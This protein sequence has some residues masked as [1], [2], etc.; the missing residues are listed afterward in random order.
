LKY[1][2]I[3][4]SEDGVLIFKRYTLVLMG[5]W[6]AVANVLPISLLVKPAVQ[7]VG[8]YEENFSTY[9]YSDY[10][11]RA[12]WDIWNGRMALASTDAV[13]HKLPAM[14][15]N[16]AGTTV[17]VW[18]RGEHGARDIYAQ[19]LDA[20]GNPLWP[21]DVRVPL[22]LS[23]SERWGPSVAVDESGNAFIVWSDM[24]NGHTDVYAQKL[25]PWG[26][27]TWDTDVR[28]NTDLGTANQWG[29]EVAVDSLANIWIAWSDYRNGDGDIYAQRINPN[30]DQLLPEDVR[31]N[32]DTGEASQYGSDIA[33]VDGE[34]LVVVWRDAT[35]GLNTLYAQRVDGEGDHL[36]TTDQLVSDS[37]VSYQYPVFSDVAADPEGYVVVVWSY[38][39]SYG[40]GTPVYAQRLT[41]EG[42]RLWA[43]DVEV[44]ASPSIE[45]QNAPA[46]A[47]SDTGSAYVAW[48]SR[49]SS[50]SGSQVFAQRLDVLGHRVWITDTE[51]SSAHDIVAYQSFTTLGI[52]SVGEVT[53]VW[54]DTRHVSSSIF[55]QRLTTSGRPLWGADVRVNTGSGTAVQETPAVAMDRHGN[56]FVVWQDQ[57]NGGYDIYAQKFDQVGHRL[58][59]ADVQVASDVS[60]G[61][62]WPHPSMA[63]DGS[64]N[65]IVVWMGSQGGNRD[66]YAQKL[67]G[68]GNLQWGKGVRV[69]A[70]DATIDQDDW[71]HPS[72]SAYGDTGVVVVWCDERDG[73]NRNIYVQKIDEHG[74]RAWSD[75]KRV[76]AMSVGN[77]YSPMVASNA[78]HIVVAWYWNDG[79]ENRVL[80]Q[81]LDANGDRVWGD[82]VQ[83][84]TEA[85]SVWAN[86]SLAVGIDPHGLASVAWED[87]RNDRDLYMQRVDITG[88]RVWGEDVKVNLGGRVTVLESA[89]VVNADDCTVLLWLGYYSGE[90]VV[91]AQGIDGVGGHLREV[92]LR[93]S[94]DEARS[95]WWYALAGDG[96]GDFVAAWIDYRNSNPDIYA[97]RFNVEGGHAWSA[98]LQVVAPDEFYFLDGFVQSRTVDVFVDAITEATLT[99]YSYFYGGKIQF[100]LSNDG[101]AHW[102]PITP[103]VTHV[104]TTTGSDLRWRAHLMGDPVWR[105][106]SP[107]VESLRI[108]YATTTNSGDDYEPDDTCAQA[109]PIQVGGNAQAHAF[110]QYQ[111]SDWVWFDAE[112]GS[113]YLLQTSN[114]GARADTILELY[115]Q[116][117]QPPEDSDDNAFGPGATLAF[118]APATGRYYARVLQ[119]DGS[120]YG[121]DTHYDLTVRAQQA[122]QSLGAAIIVAGRLRHND[123]VQPIINATANLA[124][125]TLLQ[126]GFGADDIYYLNS[127]PAQPGVDAVPTEENVRE[128]IQTWARA[129]VG[130][131]A[132]LWLYLADHGQVDR[133]Y[134]EI[135]ETITAAELDLWLSNLKQHTGVDEI[136]VIIDACYAGSFIDTHESGGW[137]A[138][139]ISG[140]GRVVVASTSSH[141]WAYA[142]RIVPGQPTPVMYFS[143]GLWRALGEG[144]D[145]WHAFL[146]G[147]AEVDAG[148]VG[149]C[150]DYDYRCQR[151]WLDDTGDAWFDGEDGQLAQ[152][153]G[154]AA[155]FDGGIAP[156]AEYVTS[157]EITAGAATIEAR[158]VDDGSVARVW[159]R[160]FAPSFEVPTSSDGSIPVVE[161]PEVELLSVGNDVYRVT[162]D[163]FTEEGAYQVVVYAMD[164]EG[165]VSAPKTVLVGGQKVYLPLILRGG[166]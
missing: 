105:H 20:A 126:Q 50:D 77:H 46:V 129:R 110:H 53:V 13:D 67:D 66:I 93:V 32:T 157:S 85:A 99:T 75:E 6:I 83:V 60:D 115:N 16:D 15:V 36:W 4:Q 121:A 5:F 124:Y 9:A 114:T 149:G 44:S 160:P 52:D 130:L 154:L 1:I 117:G 33:V 104:F 111:D 145:L 2:Q 10:V 123:P 90:R 134:N 91:Y 155:S 152:V 28:V 148:G 128:A 133:F 73:N 38:D 63:V 42:D 144:Q 125:Q 150:G 112:A 55:A 135:G 26:N 136:N 101:G 8:I 118:I 24:R 61:T 70:S 162:H 31:L 23:A 43:G 37:E 35:D 147:R 92:D 25:D 39:G 153:R 49:S 17:V 151:P 71:S 27:H 89:L 166:L 165:N 109:Q 116:C 41:P 131:E 40:Y 94:G 146:V 29:A 158:V 137:G 34:S 106:R 103:G 78:L 161:V 138:W 45:W 97:Q 142:P 159:A 72:V 3:N 127:D 51:V 7:S 120:V 57:R 11:E 80:A 164:D 30:G 108:E 139:E 119:H 86:S 21:S 88:N 87:H 132:P 18:E 84:N 74:V 58:W 65:L 98:D 59:A 68:E 69:N 96:N 54:Q 100:Y 47:V 12:R 79:G 81:Q 95:P 76:S 102:A 48:E 163:G 143:G 62:L 56:T 107:I 156:Y 113:S 64:G 19:R 140:H 14:A 82:D 22:N 122:Q 141:W